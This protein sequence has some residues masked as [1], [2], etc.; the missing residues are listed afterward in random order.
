MKN[1]KDVVDKQHSKITH[2][3]SAV[4]ILRG[5]KSL[6]TIHI[7]QLQDRINRLEKELDQEKHK[8]M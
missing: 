6:L 8:N 3:E 5:D 7:N 2:L 4:E 1:L